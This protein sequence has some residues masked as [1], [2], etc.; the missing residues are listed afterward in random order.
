MAERAYA[1]LS[2]LMQHQFREKKPII[3]FASRGEDLDEEPA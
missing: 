2:R 1:R 3:L